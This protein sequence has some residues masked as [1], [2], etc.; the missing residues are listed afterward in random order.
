[1]TVHSHP[2]E[3][4]LLNIYNSGHSMATVKIEKLELQM[5]GKNFS[6]ASFIHSP[7]TAFNQKRNGLVQQINQ[8]QLQIRI[9][10]LR[11]SVY[12]ITQCILAIMYIC[13]FFLYNWLILVK[14]T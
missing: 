11:G 3:S 9:F 7:P 1:M 12:K 6:V 10:R 2:I 5:D 13:S 14:M 4:C 8:Y